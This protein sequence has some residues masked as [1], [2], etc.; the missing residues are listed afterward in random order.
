MTREDSRPDKA[1]RGKRP[2]VAAAASGPGR[3]LVIGGT[4]FIGSEVVFE[5]LGTGASVAV[6]ARNPPTDWRQPWLGQ[7]DLFIGSADD[8]T[9]L[10]RALVDVD[11][12]VYAVSCPPPSA[13]LDPSGSV[14]QTVPMLIRVLD[15]VRERPGVGLTYLSSGGTVYGNPDV[16]PAAESSACAPVSAYGITKLLGEKSVDEYASAYGIPT[17]ILRVANAYGPMQSAADGQGI[18]AVLMEAARTGG[19]VD[20]FG[21]GSSVRDY[22]H[23]TDVARAVVRLPPV[24]GEP[25]VVNVGSG[26]GT[27]IRQV[28]EIVNRVTGSPVPVRWSEERGF[29]VRSIVLDLTRLNQHLDWEPRDLETGTAQMWDQLLSWNSESTELEPA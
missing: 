8:P 1:I 17:R 22:V 28:I 11:W 29:D 7:A 9:V 10:S 27:S 15:A 21:D 23:V 25:Q 19:T 24:Q 18:V 6:L 16:L 12:V 13:D 20:I 3:V 26:T 5:L 2:V 4:G 14:A